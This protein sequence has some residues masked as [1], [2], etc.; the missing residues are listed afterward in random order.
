MLMPGGGSHK[1]APGQGTD[2][3]ELSTSMMLGIIDHNIQSY[4]DGNQ[5]VALNMDKVC[6]RYKDWYESDPFDCGSTVRGALGALTRHW[7]ELSD[8]WELIIRESASRDIY[9]VSEAVNKSSKSNGSLMKI[10]P[11]AVWAAEVLL[12]DSDENRKHFK[13]IIDADAKII[14][15]E[16]MT[17]CCIYVY[18]GAIAYLINHKDD[19]NRA[20]AAIN[21]AMDLANGPYGNKVADNGAASAAIWI[22]EAS[23]LWKKCKAVDSWIFN[24]SI[25]RIEERYKCTEAIGFI[26][27]AFIL[28][29]YYLF[30]AAD[31]GED[32]N[33][34]YDLETEKG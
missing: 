18:A 2:D 5:V 19:K 25:E 21:Y 27:H 14:H 20:E 1:T 6:V 24:P 8:D 13:E 15:S 3:S 29:F 32:G 11:M 30:K 12:N 9:K 34:T 31:I 28:S 4:M 23:D 16:E 10:C 33:L 26:K 7:R 22:Q 17:R